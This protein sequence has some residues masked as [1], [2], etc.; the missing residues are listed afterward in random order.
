MS[1][2]SSKL[3]EQHD[4]AETDQIIAG[5]FAMLMKSKP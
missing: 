3:S 4:F 2:A 5:N 1:A